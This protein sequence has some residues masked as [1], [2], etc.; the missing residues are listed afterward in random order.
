[1]YLAEPCFFFVRGD[2]GTLR[3]QA[4]QVQGTQGAS[5]PGLGAEIQDSL[6][7][8]FLASYGKINEPFT[9][10]RCTPPLF[11]P[12]SCWWFIILHAKLLNCALLTDAQ[13]LLPVTYSAVT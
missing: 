11:L 7:E 9:N 3:V 10:T 8:Q 5:I 4:L 13:G 12:L 2:P 6:R 1:M